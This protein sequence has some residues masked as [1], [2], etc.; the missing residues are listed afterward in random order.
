MEWLR[1]WSWRIS[2]V[3][4]PWQMRWFSA[5]GGPASGGQDL[6]IGG[7]PWEQGRLSVY[8]SWLPMILTVFFACARFKE[9]LD[10][11]PLSVS[12]WAV[13]VGMLLL[14]L[15]A[16]VSVY[17]QASWQWL[18]Q[19]ILLAFFAWSLR[20]LRLGRR[21]LLA[22][23]VISIV[24]HA[25]LGLW[26]FASQSVMGSKWLGIASQNPADPGVSVVASGGRR[27][28]RAYGGFPHPNIFGGWLAFGLLAAAWLAASLK[29]RRARIAL[30]AAAAL[31]AAALVLTFSR[32]AWIAAAVGVAAVLVLTWKKAWTLEEKL[33]LFL[34]PIVIIVTAAGALAATWDLVSVRAMPDSRLEVKSVDER[35]AA[36]SAAWKLVGEEWW[37]GQGQNTAIYALDR[38]GLGIVPPH[39]I[40]LLI[41]LETGLIGSLGAAL[42]LLRWLRH[43][44]TE[45]FLMLAVVAPLALFD[46]YLWSLW[47]GQSLAMWFAVLPFV[48]RSSLMAHRSS[49]PE[50]T[51][52]EK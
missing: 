30:A 25:L 3:L 17:P 21:E 29:G 13:V 28:L 5:G 44:R 32:A 33:R 31:F 12:D 19:V 1:N 34:A 40:F 8:L 26:Q 41:L 15:P 37:L 35:A 39:F 27:V 14:G 18:T 49:S 6:L 45:G 48:N 22:W 43:A 9:D 51:S 36:L 50:L 46:H 16:F 38:A 4:L 42:L 23:C 7:L 20:Q 24:P 2:I 47:A 10:D 11:T 52:E